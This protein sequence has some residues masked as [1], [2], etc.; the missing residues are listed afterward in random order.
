[1]Q[2]IKVVI[3]RAK[4]RTGAGG[5]H[6]S[7][8][9]RT[10]LLND[11]GFQCCLGFCVRAAVP[12][13]NILGVHM[14]AGLA[15]SI[16]ELSEPNLI[17]RSNYSKNTVLA[18]RAATINDDRFLRRAEREAELLELFRDSIYAIEFF[19]EYTNAKDQ[20]DD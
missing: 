7:G 18:N 16:P 14:P 9:G 2:K 15:G 8:I 3:D 1:M 6:E 17:S 20:S 11:S 19:G 10:Q 13:A 4:W 5:A 12:N